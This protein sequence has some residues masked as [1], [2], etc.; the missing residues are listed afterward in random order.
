MFLGRKFLSMEN[1]KKFWT[2]MIIISCTFWG[3]SGIF[4]KFIFNLDRSNTP[5]FVSQI[6]MIISGLVILF[7]SWLNKDKPMEIWKTKKNR[8]YFE[9]LLLLLI[10]RIIIGFNIKKGI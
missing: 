6:R 4:A 10:R 7:F 2:I 3:I 9:I 8:L 1:K 5:I